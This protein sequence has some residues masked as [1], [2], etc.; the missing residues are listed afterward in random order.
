MSIEQVVLSNLLLDD[1]YARRVVPYLRVE[2][3]REPTDQLV[4]KLIDQYIGEYNV[5]PT[6]KELL[7]ELD[8]L[9]GVPEGIHKGSKDLISSL[10]NTKLDN[11][12]WLLDSTEEF[13]KDRAIAVALLKAIEINDDKTGKLSKGAIPQILTEALS[14]SFDTNIGHDYLEDAEDRWEYYHIVEKRIPFHLDL[15]NRIT[16]GGIVPKTLTVAI[17]GT[18]VGKSLM[19]CDFAAA[20]LSMG[21]NVLYLTMEMAEEKIAERI[22]ANL[23]NIELDKLEGLS[24]QEFLAKIH[25]IKSKTAGKILIKEYPNGSANANHF[26][27]LLNE[28]KLKKTFQPDIIYI[29]YLN[30]CA[31]SRLKMSQV[32]SYQYIKSIAEELR[33]LAQEFNIPIFSAT[34]TNREGI[35]SS[36]VSMTDTSE[37]IGLPMTVDLMFALMQPEEFAERQQFLVKQLK[38]RYSDPDKLRRFV[39]GVDKSKM[40]LYDVEQDAQQNI[41]GG[42]IE[43]PVFGE[44]KKPSFDGFE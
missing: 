35:G 33:A 13:C 20:H 29:D 19:M 42:L 7:V 40:R 41:M 21:Y 25:A 37:S 28:L 26:R 9:H 23:C 43:K 39:I 4:Y 34:Q 38:N 22:D 6:K 14:V 30:I 3:F 10:D 27:F 8:K 36:D 15:L 2:Y 44:K 11:E 18:G 16:R 12:K 31:S 24:K 1:A 17:A 5:L 32:N